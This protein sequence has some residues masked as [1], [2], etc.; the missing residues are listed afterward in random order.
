MQAGVTQRLCGRRTGACMH[1]RLALSPPPCPPRQL[2]APP[3]NPLLPLQLPAALCGGRPVCALHPPEPAPAPHQPALLPARVLALL[4]AALAGTRGG[5]GRGLGGLRARSCLARLLAGT[6]EACVCAPDAG[7]ARPPPALPC[8]QAIDS[9]LI[10][11]RARRFLLLK[12]RGRPGG[13]QEC[14]AVLP[15]CLPALQSPHE[16]IANALAC[17][18]GL[19]PRRRAACSPSSC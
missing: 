19:P 17:T 6:L 10:R 7:A 16:C 1:G 8:P 5:R 12:V 4:H 2:S 15:A 18:E 14:A 9:L 3:P 13:L 11:M